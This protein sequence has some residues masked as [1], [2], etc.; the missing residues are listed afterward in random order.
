MMMCFV[1]MGPQPGQT[2]CPCELAAAEIRQKNAEK[3]TDKPADD[4]ADHYRER[5][6]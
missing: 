6:E 5:R 2:L 3:K 4:K 1:C